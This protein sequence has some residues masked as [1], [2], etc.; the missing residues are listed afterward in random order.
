MSNVPHEP[1][2][3]SLGTQGRPNQ[4]LIRPLVA[5]KSLDKSLFELCP[6]LLMSSLKALL[7]IE[8]FK[9]PIEPL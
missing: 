3:K 6:K 1:V 2:A 5:P 9:D 7:G 8:S 4:S